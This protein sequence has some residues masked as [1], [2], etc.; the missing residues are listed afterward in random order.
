MSDVKFVYLYRD[1]SNYKNWGEI[2]FSNPELLVPR[3][4]EVALRGEFLE[5]GLFIAHQ[6]RIPEIFLSFGDSLTVDD[7]CFHEFSGTEATSL[8]PNDLLGRSIHEFMR[9]V[10]DEARRGWRPFEP[11]ESLSRRRVSG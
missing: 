7:H 3:D 11:L 4:I 8:Q 6:V 9:E 1:G 5:D 2:V 10:T